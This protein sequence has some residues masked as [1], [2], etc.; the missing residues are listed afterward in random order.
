M[1]IKMLA[2]ITV[3]AF[4]A[5]AANGQSAGG[6]GAGSAG[7]AGGTS[8]GAG[9]TSGGVGT[10][11]GAPSGVNSGGMSPGINNPSTHIV[12]PANPGGVTPV[13]PNGSTPTA[14]ASLGA[15]NLAM[16]TNNMGI[17]SNNVG[18]GQNQFAFRTN[19]FGSS[20]NN[21]FGFQT[22]GLGTNNLTPLTPTGTNN[23]R[24][25]LNP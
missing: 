5:L 25:L 1:K 12:S 7:G 6:A 16:P 15:N 10:A 9:G 20:N 21:Q 24:I 18:I 22:N 19:G 4:L 11:P 8:G 14:G 2:T 3:A 17:A 13:N 23:N